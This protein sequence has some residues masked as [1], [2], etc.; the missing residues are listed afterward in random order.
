LRGGQLFGVGAVFRM[1]K[2]PS[3]QVLRAVAAL[4]VLGVHIAGEVQFSTSTEVPRWMGIGSAGVDLFFV[5]SGFVMVHAS[6]ELFGQKDARGAFI[7]RR[8]ARIAPLYWLVSGVLLFH[9]VW[10]YDSTAMA[11][12]NLS[13]AQIAASF[14]FVPWPRPSGE[15]EPLLAVGWT[16]NYEMF[17]YIVLAATLALPR[18]T[19]V[20][21]AAIILVVA[22]TIAGATS[23]W[24]APIATEF[25][26]GMA[27][28]L[29][30][31][32]VK[33]SRGAATTLMTAGAIAF[34]ASAELSSHS[35]WRFAVWGIPA[36][37]IVAGAAMHRFDLS[38][39]IWSPALLLGEA[40]YALYLVHPFMS[41]PR[42]ITQRTLGVAAG[43]WDS[44]PFAYSILLAAV[45]LPIAVAVHLVIERPITRF[46]SGLAAGYVSNR[47]VTAVS[48]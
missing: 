7:I 27:I 26:F 37:C 38:A 48:E 13:P 6:R 10:R 9:A 25:I 35:E 46:L 4:M 28:A 18:R 44:H 20:T 14:L 32:E 5:V 24:P 22:M 11:A 33:L 42:L 16:L 29:A 3:I 39:R 34:I 8:L 17:F 30:A 41:L 45:V 1:R 40:S 12:A 2:I 15:F 31:E 47:R 19:A 21:A 23:G 36:A 43:I